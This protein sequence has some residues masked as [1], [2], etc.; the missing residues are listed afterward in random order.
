MTVYLRA[1]RLTCALSLLA[2]L[3]ACGGDGNG[4]C[5]G[6]SCTPTGLEITTTTSAIKIGQT[7]TYT[8]TVIRSDNSR[9]V[10]TAGWE[11]DTPSVLTI[12]SAGRALGVSAGLASITASYQGIRSRGKPIQ[13]VPD[14][15]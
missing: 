13:V 9:E 10:V 11:T 8:A 5:Q 12:D 7:E 14:Y 15:Q 6:P 2:L 1:V 3:V 4:E